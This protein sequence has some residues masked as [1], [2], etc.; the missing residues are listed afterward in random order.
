M[1]T[2]KQIGD[3]GED[4]AAEYLTSQGYLIVERNY[5]TRLGEIDIIALDG[6]VLVFVEVKK[7]KSNRFG[8]AGEMITPDKIKKIIRTAEMYIAESDL[9]DV[10]WR[11]DAVLIDGSEI[12]HLKSVSL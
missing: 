8:T 10:D 6:E 12:E 1:R 2:T 5:R 9:G 11:I 3:Q 4:M 7:K